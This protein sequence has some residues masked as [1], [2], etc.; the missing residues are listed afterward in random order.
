MRKRNDAWN[1]R[2][3]QASSIPD[4]LDERLEQAIKQGARQERISK[5]I[6][7]VAAAVLGMAAMFVMLV[8]SSVS[9]ALAASR[10]PIVGALVEAVVLDPSLKAAVAHEYVQ[11][12]DKTYTQDGVTLEMEY[13][14]ADPKNLSV[15]YRVYDAEGRD[16]TLRRTLKDET[17][18]EIS[19]SGSYGQ[20]ML[21]REPG[22]K[23]WLTQLKTFFRGENAEHPIYYWKFH[24]DELP[25]QLQIEAEVYQYAGV[26]EFP[27][28]IC[29]EVPIAIEP[30]FLKSVKTFPVNQTVSVL[31]Q[32]LT[33][34]T[35][36]VYPTNTRIAWHTAPENDSWL[37]YLPF[38]L[39]NEAG[40]RVDG[41]RNG[42]SAVGGD[43]NTGEGE[44][45]LESAWY[46]T[47]ESLTLHLDDA[48]VLPK[49][50]PPAILH[51]DGTL[52]GLPAYIKQIP[53][54]GFSDFDVLTQKGTYDSNTD[55]FSHFVDADGKEGR[56]AEVTSRMREDKST[57]HSGYPM[58]KKVKYPLEL[59]IDFAPAQRLESTV[60]IAVK[61]SEK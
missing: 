61:E 8:N 14:I 10:V 47:V 20:E 42:V 7:S 21:E 48:A 55:P 11:L 53:S 44:V 49:D 5:R 51:E 59:T 16:I 18:D 24:I 26:T 29:F 40:I 30:Q 56:F 9:F 60:E 54:D 32:K 37:T 27:L 45:W 31:G 4:S 46:D 35:I 3:T 1:T 12:I 28:D 2:I 23:N 43:M 58:P 25:E 39:T 50:T 41:I 15:F 22:E 36:D 38:Y 6:R 57:M 17:G 34:D 19:A 33:I 52:T 13:L